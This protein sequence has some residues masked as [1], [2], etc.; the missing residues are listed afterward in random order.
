MVF[1]LSLRCFS[2]RHHHHP[3]LCIRTRSWN[4][5]WS[6]SQ[7]QRSDMSTNSKIVTNPTGDDSPKHK[8]TL[9]TPQFSLPIPPTSI[10]N[11]VQPDYW[12]PRNTSIPYDWSCPSHEFYQWTLSSTFSP[13]FSD[14]RRKLDYSYHTHVV[15]QRQYLQDAILQ[16]IVE[17]QVTAKDSFLGEKIGVTE[18]NMLDVD[19]QDTESFSTN[20]TEDDARDV[21][22]EVK[23]ESLRQRP[24]IIFTAG[25]MG[26]GKGY[27]LTQL[28]QRNLMNL[29]DFVK[30]DPDLI[31]FE[32]PEMTGY[33]QK[34]RATASTKLHRESTQ[35]ADIIFEY[36]ITNSMSILVDGSL[37]DVVYYQSLFHRIRT[38]YS[39]YR[40]GIIHITASRDAIFDR[41]TARATIMGRVVPTQLLEESIEQVPKSVAIL[42]PL[43]DVVHVISN[44]PDQPLEL[45]SSTV[46]HAN[47]NQI[48]SRPAS[49]VITTWNDFAHSW[50]REAVTADGTVDAMIAS[51]SL[52]AERT[53]E[54]ITDTTD[55]SSRDSSRETFSCKLQST[56][57][58]SLSFD[59][60]D[61]HKIANQI[62]QNSYPNFCAR[63]LITTDGQCGRC[64]HN[65][66]LC[67]CD[68]CRPCSNSNSCNQQ[69]D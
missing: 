16:R 14:A 22:H 34:D 38:E 52:S 1:F 67:A 11:I 55:L 48:E 43:A 42:S 30:I 60:S 18:M 20:K 65:A 32:L 47:V 10:S 41:A 49:Q 28:H 68:L 39:S 62:W 5:N 53:N 56:R 23:R 17:P 45:I 24:W 37:R 27:V 69:N 7:T 31:K 51:D 21:N 64:I 19:I 35:M 50:Y 40:I 44:Q 36:A 9:P 29:D 12:P 59:D 33:L 6:V 58:M 3:T 57:P 63:C 54:V 61:S 15:L 66:H 8:H 4:S 25:P 26:V 2:N 13:T 46:Q